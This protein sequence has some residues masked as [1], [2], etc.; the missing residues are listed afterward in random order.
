MRRV[1]VDPEFPQRDA[2]EEAASRISSGG[3]VVVP[4]DTLYGLAVNPFRNDSVAR[5]FEV[6]RRPPERGLPL[7]ASDAA[8]VSAHIGPLGSL[9]K[10]LAD[11]FW[12]GPLTL[13]VKAPE[14]VS[15][16]VTGGSPKVGVRVPADRVARAICKACNRPITA[17]SANL[18][19]QPPT[20]DPDEVERQFR[21]RAHL[22]DL[23]IDVGQLAGGAPS[24]IVDVTGRAP[25]LVRPG[26][27]S[28][29]DIEACLAAEHQ[30]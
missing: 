13:L 15:P 16:T 30:K 9:G 24:T 18:S 21:E 5:V 3:V 22:V 28:W 8:Q 2:I 23:I 19:G 6:K 1:F 20:A 25:V 12:P 29:E 26:A 10:T 7:I 11:R 27:V 4:T 14:T 17:T